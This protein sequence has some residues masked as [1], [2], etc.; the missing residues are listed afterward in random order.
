MRPFVFATGSDHR[1]LVGR[2]RSIRAR[3]I[4]REFQS[5]QRRPRGEQSNV[6]EQ[7]RVD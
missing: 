4:S 5:L 6:S 1:N 7:L 3:R 2:S